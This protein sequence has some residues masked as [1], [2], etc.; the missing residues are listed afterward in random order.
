V[1][2]GGVLVGRIVLARGGEIWLSAWAGRDPVSRVL[3]VIGRWSLLIYLLHQPI[4]FGAASVVAPH[5]GPSE[6]AISNQFMEQC[7]VTCR[8]AGRDTPTC[9]LYCGCVL[10]GLK[11]ANLVTRLTRLTDSERSTWLGIVNECRPKAAPPAG[12]QSSGQ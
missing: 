12:D 2:L 9:E 11:D 5:I 10:S 3:A 6:Q 7:P 4:L 8:A 1:V